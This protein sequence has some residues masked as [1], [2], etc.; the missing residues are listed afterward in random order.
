[1][2]S[3]LFCERDSDEE[4]LRDA[5]ELDEYEEAGR[6]LPFV[7]NET[8]SMMLGF[9]SAFTAVVL[10]GHYWFFGGTPETDY[11]CDYD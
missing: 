5:A 6:W 7:S 10:I 1:M 9:M 8:V 11:D 4:E 3:R 2:K